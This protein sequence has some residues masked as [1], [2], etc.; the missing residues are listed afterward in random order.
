MPGFQF[1]RTAAPLD[2]Y[3]M[4]IKHLSSFVFRAVSSFDE[5]IAPP[6]RTRTQP[7]LHKDARRPR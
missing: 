1:K 4:D 6:V 7:E 5:R 2:L 3:S